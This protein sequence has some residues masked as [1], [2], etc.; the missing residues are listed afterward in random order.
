M[1]EE[2]KIKSE[3]EK[4]ILNTKKTLSWIFGIV[5]M[6][7]FSHITFNML[8]TDLENRVIVLLPCLFLSVVLGSTLHDYL[9]GD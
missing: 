5:M 1:D 3:S 2:R 7:L 6:M 9:N 8:F 4:K